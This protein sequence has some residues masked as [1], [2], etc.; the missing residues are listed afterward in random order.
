MSILIFVY[1]KHIVLLLVIFYLQKAGRYQLKYQR[2]YG[3]YG[4]TSSPLNML[5]FI[6]F[7]MEMSNIHALM[8]CS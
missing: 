3:R 1:V 2:K 5:Y 4:I 7:C 6:L 8:L